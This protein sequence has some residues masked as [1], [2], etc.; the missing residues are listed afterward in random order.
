MSNTFVDLSNASALRPLAAMLAALGAIIDPVTR[1]WV[2]I[3]AFA[4]DLLLHHYLGLPIRRMTRDIDLAVA[5][6]SWEDFEEIRKEIRKNGGSIGAEAQRANLGGLSFDIVPFGG[7]AEDDQIR[8]P[9]DSTRNWWE[10][11]Y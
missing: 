10:P 6:R 5:V 1:D 4:R 3:G 7:V 11:R 9:P 2:I 8:C